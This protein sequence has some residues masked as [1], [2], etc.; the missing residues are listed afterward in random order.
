MLLTEKKKV[1]E[2]S[3]LVLLLALRA[4]LIA[5]RAVLIATCEKSPY[6]LH[7]DDGHHDGHYDNDIVLRAHTTLKV[8]LRDMRRRP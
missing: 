4:L 6:A 7:D 3:I 5:A 2:V 8:V 1:C